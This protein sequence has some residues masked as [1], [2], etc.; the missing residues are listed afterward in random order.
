[1]QGVVIIK[2][3]I[4]IF[5]WAHWGVIYPYGKISPWLKL[6][7]LNDVLIVFV[8]VSSEN[9]RPGTVIIFGFIN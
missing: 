2:G 5:S 9:S 6:L 7:S 4:Y 1:M 8:I 3:Q